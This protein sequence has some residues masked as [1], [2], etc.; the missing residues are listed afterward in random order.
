MIYCKKCTT[1][2]KEGSLF[3]F[4]C[5]SPLEKKGRSCNSCG[6]AMDEKANF[7]KSCGRKTEIP[8]Q[9][10]LHD[11][12]NTSA[13]PA[14]IKRKRWVLPVA[15]LSG[16]TGLGVICLAVLAIL[17]L[18]LPA[19]SALR[20]TELGESQTSTAYALE[21]SD[22]KKLSGDQKILYSVFGSPDHFI[23][24]FEY[25]E[26]GMEIARLETWAYSSMQYYYS[27]L[28]GVYIDGSSGIYPDMGDGRYLQVAPVHFTSE[29]RKKDIVELL[30]EESGIRTFEMEG[31][32]A[33]VF[34]ENDDMFFVF[35]VY[36]KIVS[37]YHSSSMAKGSQRL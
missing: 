21:E 32:Q 35:D 2:N 19:G 6:Y 12:D 20:S 15:I 14:T 29:M 30:G 11:I 23:L 36:G 7:C 22:V 26:S 18:F 8:H 33:L 24:L 3:C 4:R 17:L 31:M 28:N 10:S 37:V 27:F 25:D 34:G 5:G 1:E 16:I 13:R 9:Q